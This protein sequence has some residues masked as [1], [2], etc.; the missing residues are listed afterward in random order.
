MF[1][2]LIISAFGRII[3][4]LIKAPSVLKVIKEAI[5]DFEKVV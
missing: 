5:S 2:S 3:R 1:N 4:F